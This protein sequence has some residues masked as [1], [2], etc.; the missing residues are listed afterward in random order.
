VP[1]RADDARRPAQA[2]GLPTRRD[3]LVRRKALIEA[4]AACFVEKG[5]TVPLE[6]IADR[7]GV[8]RG[9]LYRNFRDRMELALAVFDRDIDALEAW[10]DMS[11]PI[12]QVMADILYR[13]AKVSALFTRLA[14][15]IPIDFKH[16][17]GFHALGQ[18]VAAILV[19]VVERAHADG[20]LRPEL[21]PKDLLLSMRM[22]SGLL[23]PQMSEEEVRERIEA[24]MAL[25]MPGL[26]PR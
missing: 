24:A 12:E 19:P 8:G 11:R 5:Y 13:G 15:E 7:A 6:E 18:R 17:E 16:V 25:L 23:I 10:L 20:L 9:T 22:T 1:E 2:A 21:G 3:A 14:I 4:A 26:R